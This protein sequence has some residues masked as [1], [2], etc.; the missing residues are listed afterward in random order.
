M[1]EP[2]PYL[3]VYQ[4]CVKH[5]AEQHPLYTDLYI[6]SL[7]VKRLV[8]RLV[9][10]QGNL[11]ALIGNQGVGKTS[12]LKYIRYKLS[13]QDQVCI[14]IKWAGLESIFQQLPPKYVDKDY[15]T[16]LV[17]AAQQTNKRL[18]FFPTRREYER[19]IGKNQT[20]EI[21]LK[22]AV[23]G[24]AQQ[25]A[26]ILIEFQ[27]YDKRSRGQMVRDLKEFQV[28]WSLITEHDPDS[29]LN[30]VF[31]W[32]REL[33]GG[34]FNF[35]KFDVVELKP[36][37]PETLAR[38]YEQI[39]FQSKNGFEPFTYEALML[40]AGLARGVPRW[41]K[42]YI[43]VCLDH[44]Y[45]NLETGNTVDAITEECVRQWITIELLSEDW[46][47]ELLEVFPKSMGL[48]R[49]AVQVFVHLQQHGSTTQAEIQQLMFGSESSDKMAC[50]RLLAKVEEAGY[51][52]REYDGREKM[53]RMVNQYE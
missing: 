13:R 21:Q 12:T 23:S 47:R 26:T 20:L 32:Q 41:Y 33:W 34:H 51:I 31:A 10:T 5:A 6:E 15:S 16:N 42:K 28:F 9:S 36:F 22:M 53:V 45:D 29:C 40:I 49:K 4:W 43:R 11:I 48:R 46:H 39:G 17:E 37:T 38:H 2:T 27:D 52:A 1:S 7:P 8:R 18:S 50:S 44:L 24:L 35:G 30:I 19:L 25:E 3:E 14:L